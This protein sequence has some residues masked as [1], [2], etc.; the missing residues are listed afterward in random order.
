MSSSLFRF[1]TRDL[2]GELVHIF[3]FVSSMIG[4][5]MICWTNVLEIIVHSLCSSVLMKSILA[6]LHT[7]QSAASRVWIKSWYN[8]DLN[9]TSTVS[10]Q[11]RNDECIVQAQQNKESTQEFSTFAV[12]KYEHEKVLSF[13]LDCWKSLVRLGLLW[14]HVETYEITHTAEETTRKRNANNRKRVKESLPFIIQTLF[15][16]MS[17]SVTQSTLLHG[18]EWT[19]RNPGNTQWHAHAF[20]MPSWE[21]LGTHVME[22][23]GQHID[24]ALQ[25]KKP[26]SCK[27]KIDAICGCG[28][29]SIKGTRYV[30]REF[31]ILRYVLRTTRK[32]IVIVS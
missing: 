25:W 18:D 22:N 8:T 32:V 29:L 21:E 15:F 23:N 5:L 9:W 6:I 13:S 3:I 4:M 20:M 16:F 10:F 17:L 28:E 26:L 12:L 24:C 30:A 1:E 11:K 7:H 2:L 19:Q 14:P 31:Q 27:E